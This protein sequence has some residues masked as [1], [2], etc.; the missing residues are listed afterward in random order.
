M[1][2]HWGGL[3]DF[4]SVLKQKQNSGYDT[5]SLLF[6][7]LLVYKHYEPFL[8]TWRQTYYLPIYICFLLL[9]MLIEV[10]IC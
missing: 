5:A 10:F 3:V 4:Q 9:F 7:S 2:H 1:L 6:Y 8:A